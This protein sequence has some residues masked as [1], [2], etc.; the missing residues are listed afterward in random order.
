MSALDVSKRVPGLVVAVIGVVFAYVL[1]GLVSFLVS[2]ADGSLMDHRLEEVSADIVSLHADLL[3][4]ALI[5]AV[6]MIVRR[7]MTRYVFAVA[8]A[9]SFGLGLY[10]IMDHVIHPLIVDTGVFTLIGKSAAN[11]INPQFTRAIVLILA[12]G[13]L[14][15]MCVFSSTR[16]RDR[17]FS[18]LISGAVIVTTTLFHLAL[19]MGVLRYEKERIATILVAE[20]GLVPATEF[21]TEKACLFLDDD[22]NEV[23]AKRIATSPLPPSEFLAG[24]RDAVMTGGHRT[25]YVR[26]T[27]FAGT[28]FAVDGCLERPVTDGTV[29]RYLCFSDAHALDGLGLTVAAWMGF[30]CASAHATWLFGGAFLLWLHKR[31][32][33]LRAKTAD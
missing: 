13:T 11:G 8:L 30:L 1:W 25:K 14:L 15:G 29:T 19:P 21:C 22:F 32:F 20:A 12:T 18:L 7:V 17:A 33:K 6:G 10:D 26:S 31:R 28:T 9:G 4:A 24:S 3:T 5:L 2:F 23:E 27:S 16:T